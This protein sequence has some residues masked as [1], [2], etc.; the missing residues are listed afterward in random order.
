ML[1]NAKCSVIGGEK[2]MVVR[3]GQIDVQNNR[4]LEYAEESI[5]QLIKSEYV[6]IR[7]EFTVASP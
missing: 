6:A 3:N 5:G 1:R 4:S 2:K 7:P